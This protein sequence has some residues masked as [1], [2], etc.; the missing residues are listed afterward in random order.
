VGM[1]KKETAEG[2]QDA[3]AERARRWRLSFSFFGTCFLRR[4]RT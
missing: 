2:V 4:C 1:L 3:L